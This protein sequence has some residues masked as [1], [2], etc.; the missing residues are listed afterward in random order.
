LSVICCNNR[1]VGHAYPYCKPKLIFIQG[2][3]GLLTNP[4]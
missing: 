3:S 4:V 2:F 1:P